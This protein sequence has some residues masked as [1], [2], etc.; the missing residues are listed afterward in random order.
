MLA[1]PLS[2][3]TFPL[4][5]P[6]LQSFSHGSEKDQYHARQCQPNDKLRAVKLV[7]G[8]TD[9]GSSV[10]VVRLAHGL[11]SRHLM[12]VCLGRYDNHG[13][14]TLTQQ[15]GANASLTFH[16]TAIWLF[17]AKR[18]NHGT[19]TASIDN[20]TPTNGNGHSS[21]DVFRQVLFS[22]ECSNGA[23]TVVL[24]NTGNVVGSNFLDIDY[25]RRLFMGLVM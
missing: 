7:D 15:Q 16:G 5:D 17:G 8:R 2:V 1:F 13:T 20:Q 19:Y 18:A 14:F 9:P 25:V 22:A 11:Q 12:A 10:L 6:P 21:P 3:L 4:A 23:H 24:T